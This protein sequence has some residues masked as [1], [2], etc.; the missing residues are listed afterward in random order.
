M[1]KKMKGLVFAFLIAIV[2]SGTICSFCCA[3]GKDDVVTIDLKDVDVKTAIEA[4]FNGTGIGHTI[5]PQVTGVIP[6]FSVKDTAFDVALK[7]LVK[8]AGLVYRVDNGVYMISKKPDTSDI[9]RPADTT[10]VDTAQVDTTTTAESII[11]KVRL[12]Y[13]G[14]TDLL[15]I[16]SGNTNSNNN[17]GFGGMS[18]FG[19]SSGGFGSS[20]SGFGSSSSGFGSSSGGFGSSSSSGSWGG[21]SSSRSW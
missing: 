6:V 2:A 20:S 8:T 19:S 4:L 15:N 7:I 1:S 18:G 9:A 10:P 5:D 14:A 21:S 16:L 12:S 3:A 13:T 11:D 17:S